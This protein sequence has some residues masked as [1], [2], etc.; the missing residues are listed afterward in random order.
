MVLWGKGV[1]D[2]WGECE[3]R[4]PLEEARDIVDDGLE[5]VHGLVQLPDP[6]VD[7]GLVMQRLDDQS[8]VN[9]PSTLRSILEHIFSLVQKDNGLVKLLL[10]YA[11][12]SPSIELVDLFE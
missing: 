11:L 6:L 9:G 8:T 2:I 10:R 7:A 5:V 4:L 3:L 12:G 1:G